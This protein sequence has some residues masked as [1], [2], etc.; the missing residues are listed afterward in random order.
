MK[1]ALCSD[2]ENIQIIEKPLPNIG[3]GEI[4]L[5]VEICGLCGSDIKKLQRS[6]PLQP[7]QTLGHEVVGKIHQLGEGNFPFQLGDRVVVSHHVPCFQCHYCI[8]ENY[9]M[10]PKFKKSNLD[11][12]G[13]SEFLRIPKTHVEYTTF[14]LPAEFPSE[15]A[16]FTEPLACCL[17]CLNRLP[18]KENDQVL[19][20]G[21]GSIGYLLSSLLKRIPTQVIVLDLDESRLKLAKELGAITLNPK[22]DSIENLIEIQT[23]GRGVDVVLFSAGNYSMVNQALSWIRDGGF[24]CLFAELNPNDDHPF[25]FN[26]CYHREI[27]LTSSYSPSP[28]DLKEA[29]FLITNEKLNLSKLPVHQFSLDELPKAIQKTLNREIFK[30]A[31][32]PQKESPL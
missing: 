2:Q 23:K 19:L 24:L 7:P 15:K 31:I 11:P 16:L 27:S 13:F 4:L 17:R 12:G 32:S 5:K 22:K 29:H 3:K 14:I 6:K 30:A 21:F 25:N 20:V 9:S 18:L 8:H 1:L 26:E 10:C 28:K